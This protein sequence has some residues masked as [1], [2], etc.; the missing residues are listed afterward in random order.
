LKVLLQFIS[1]NA[2]MIDKAFEVKNTEPSQ[3]STYTQELQATATA[4]VA[5]GKGI[6]AMDESNGTCNKRFEQLGIATTE[7][8]RRVYRELILTTPNLYAYIS[9]AILFDETIH[10]S[11]STGES[12]VS[13]MQRVG[14]IPGIKVDGGAKPF[15]GHPEELLTDG[16]DGLADRVRAYYT[17]GAR[18]A[19]WRAVITIGSNIPSTACIE[20]NAAALAKYAAICQANGLVPIV[21]PEVLIN[22]NHT[23]DRCREVTAAT[24]KEVFKQLTSQGVAFDRMILK[25]SM[26]IA[27]LGATLPSPVNEVAIATIE[28]LIEEVPPTVAGIAFLSGGQTNEQ[29]SAHLN[30]MNVMFP[31]APWP[32]TFSYA[33]AIQQ[34]ALAKWRGES[35]NV[36][37][38]QQILAHRA[39]CNSAAS[40]GTYTAHTEKQLVLV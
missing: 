15:A 3:M 20:A 35:G 11:T 26:V 9:G 31:Q 28:T 6:L 34:S 40:T 5:K 39:A 18:F 27:G 14:M 13:L 22:G 8:N 12:F 32:V 36:A 17:L 25:P 38:A 24:L 2:T 30:A 29:A 10:Q 21:E 37:I 1:N 33:R 16:L 23:L 19:K 4:L 7:E